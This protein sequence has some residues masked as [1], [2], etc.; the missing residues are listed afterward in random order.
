MK[1]VYLIMAALLTAA[2]AWA[3]RQAPR[4]IID[5]DANSYYSDDKHSVVDLELRAKNIAST[6]P[7]EDFLS[8]VARSAS[9]YQAHGK[10]A[11]AACA[12]GWLEQWAARRAMLG[13]MS[14]AQAYSVR[15][16]TLGGLALSYAR[17]RETATPAQRYAIDAWLSSIADST[18]SYAQVRKGVRNNHYYWEGMAVTA[19]GAVTQNQRYLE[20]G[21]DVFDYAM[22]QVAEDGSLPAEMARGAKALHYHV[23]AAAPL[24]MIESMLNL[25]SL[26]FERLVKFT[27]AAARDP[28][29]LKKTTGFTQE[30]PASMPFVLIYQRHH[31]QAGNAVV[32]QSGATNKTTW[33]AR[34]GGDLTLANPLEHP[35]P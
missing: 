18:I 30:K 22:G 8:G 28:S 32:D 7:V 24:A 16:W 27:L 1:T 31:G 14:S 5:I 3:C 9:R 4:P 26:S 29:A 17:V 23:F 20:W 21:R 6:R 15:K 25:Q 35:A 12:L 33:Q 2:P 10:P 13:R 19:V 11:D 34:L